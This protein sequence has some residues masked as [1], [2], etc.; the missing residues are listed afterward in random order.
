VKINARQLKSVYVIHTEVKL[1][2]VCCKGTDK[3]RLEQAMKA[4]NGSRIIA[5]LFL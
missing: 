5:P 4:Q 1:D 3:V 2:S